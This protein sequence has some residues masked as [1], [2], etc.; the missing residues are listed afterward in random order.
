MLPSRGKFDRQRTFSGPSQFERSANFPDIL[1]P[2]IFDGEAGVGLEGFSRVFIQDIE[3]PQSFDGDGRAS[4]PVFAVLNLEGE[5][6]PFRPALAGEHARRV[7]A[8]GPDLRD[9]RGPARAHDLRVEA[10]PRPAD[11]LR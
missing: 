2:V 9:D 3:L 5:P 8:L 7:D 10:I 1:A 6:E 11:H 4:T